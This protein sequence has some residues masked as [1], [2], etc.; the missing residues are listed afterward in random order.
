MKLLLTLCAVALAAAACATTDT[1]QV[2]QADCKIAPITT[3]NAAGGD[4]LG[5]YNNL[6]QRYAEM[7]LST[8]EYRRQLYAKQGM[9]NNNVEDA[10]KN[11]Y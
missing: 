10:L 2:A 9:S 5:T 3:R 11:C 8:S 7:Q 1:T 4:H 6:D